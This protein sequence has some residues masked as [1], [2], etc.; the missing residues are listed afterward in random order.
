[1]ALLGACAAKIAKLIP[2]LATE[3]DGEVVATVQAIGRTLQGGGKDFHDLAKAVQCPEGPAPTPPSTPQN[4]AELCDFCLA[5][6]EFLKPKEE[7][8]LRDIG[9]RLIIGGN[10]T[11]KQATWLRAIYAKVKRMRAQ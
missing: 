1:M 7:N 11:D 9:P 6:P 3:H 8:F 4:W 10:P 5:F 2:R